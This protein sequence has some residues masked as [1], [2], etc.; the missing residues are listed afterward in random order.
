[1]SKQRIMCFLQHNKLKD[2]NKMLLLAV[3]NLL[4]PIRQ[5]KYIFKI[6]AKKKLQLLSR[7]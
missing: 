3:R 1:M 2:Q 5:P 4:H 7:T 6:K